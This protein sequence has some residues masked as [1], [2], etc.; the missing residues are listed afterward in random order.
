VAGTIEQGRKAFGRQAWGEA[1]RLLAD[2]I[3]PEDLERLAIAAYLVGRDGE[4]DAALERAHH[5]WMQRA[6][7]DAA[8]RCAFWLGFSLML[9][10]EGAR[11]GGWLA[12][13]RRTIDD[14][15]VDCVTRGWLLVP[16]AFE[17]LHGGE[18]DTAFDQSSEAA[19]IGRRFG[20]VDLLAFGWL[21]QGEATIAQG[22]VARGV[23]HLDEVMVTVTTAEVSPLSAGILYCAVIEACMGVFDLARAAEWTEALHSWCEE[24]P[25]LVPYRGQCLV[26]RSQILQAHGEWQDAADEAQRAC[27]WLSK[28]PHPM[29]GSALYERA[30][31]HRLRGELDLAE[32][33]YR[34]AGV[35]G[36][37]PVPG[38][39]LLRLAQ[40]RVDAAAASIR[41]M[42]D[43]PPDPLI[44]PSVLAACVEVL[45]AAGDLDG[46]RAASHELSTLA[47][48]SV[49]VLQAMA[50]HAVGCVLLAEGDPSGA[51]GPLRRASAGWRQL[52]MRFDAARAGVSIG[53][54]CRA[55][56]DEDAAG[57]EL[58]A[59][60]VA[61]ERLEA[62]TELSR[63]D[64]VTHR[65][66]P[67][68]VLTERECEVLRLV[69]DGRTN[70]E[71]GIELGISEHTVARHVQNIFTKLGV[72][73][74]AAATAHAYEQHLV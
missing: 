11:A 7:P 21:G 46:A 67:P 40:G 4:S 6:V 1:H 69:A 38:L 15:G 61:F 22:D 48:R 30:E 52:G 50:A 27:E 17:S 20:D 60:R 18:L 70:R 10:G 74:R 66:P 12:R 43:E 55:L 9:R 42:T 16:A 23:R 2:A 59:A 39:A 63:L 19:E 34:A 71:I 14:A 31:L 13:S 24:Q 72:S 56:G 35:H 58:Q 25:D 49:P 47:D 62:G 26:H 57:V 68:K 28:P 37:Q 45:I 32:N 53:L 33:A 64:G 3:D 8:A 73:S 65:A 41:R 51:L 5:E 29:L 36:R 54:A 44:R